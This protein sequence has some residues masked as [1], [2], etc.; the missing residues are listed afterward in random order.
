VF[1]SLLLLGLAGYMDAAQAL[2][3][4]L[5]FRLLYYIMPA[6]LAG[7]AFFGHE[8]WLGFSRQPPSEKPAPAERGKK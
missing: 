4:I 7:L 2:A 8:I 6:G 1:D 5:L 3:A